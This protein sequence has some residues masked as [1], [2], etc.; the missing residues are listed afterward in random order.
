M[1]TLGNTNSTLAA[2][3]DFMLTPAMQQQ[4]QK[5]NYLPSSVMMQGPIARTS[6]QHIVSSQEGKVPY[7]VL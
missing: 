6:T 4:A 2:F 5:M 7:A 1:Y 3:L